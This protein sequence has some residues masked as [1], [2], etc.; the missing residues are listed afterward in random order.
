VSIELTL[1]VVVGDDFHRFLRELLRLVQRDLQFQVSL[2]DEKL[3]EK[4]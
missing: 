3:F 1:E 2:N 4:K